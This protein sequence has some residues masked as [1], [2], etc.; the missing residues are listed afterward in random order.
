M[1]FISLYDYVHTLNRFVPIYA[2]RVK[3]CGRWSGIKIVIFQLFVDQLV[4]ENHVFLNRELSQYFTLVGL[5]VQSSLKLQ[6]L[7]H[8]VYFFDFLVSSMKLFET[9]IVTPLVKI[10]SST[11]WRWSL[12]QLRLRTWS[13]EWIHRGERF[14]GYVICLVEY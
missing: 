1:R 2:Y 4:F 9:R 5:F 13:H 12:Q 7:I 14:F 6:I 8:T 11:R 10:R 3:A